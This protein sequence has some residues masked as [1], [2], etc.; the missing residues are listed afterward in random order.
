MIEWG[1]VLGANVVA[2]AP[3]ASTFLAADVP[4][5]SVTGCV[6]HVRAVCQTLVEPVHIDIENPK[7]AVEGREESCETFLCPYV[8]EL[9]AGPRRRS[10]SFGSLSS[11][12]SAVEWPSFR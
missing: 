6:R 3:I 2:F 7:R 8:I 12:W 4:P 10:E 11:C 1:C 9:T 5:E